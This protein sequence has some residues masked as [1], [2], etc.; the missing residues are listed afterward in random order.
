MKKG[1]KKSG[2]AG[3]VRVWLRRGEMEGVGEES[4]R[5]LASEGEGEV[6][7]DGERLCKQGSEE[8][9]KRLGEG[10]GRYGEDT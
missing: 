6:E 9:S 3:G 2:E 5:R 7:E 4:G 10:G 1:A 8:A